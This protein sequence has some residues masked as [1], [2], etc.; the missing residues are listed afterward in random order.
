MTRTSSFSFATS[1]CAASAG[2]PA[3]I[4][5]V[6]AFSGK[7]TFR[8]RCVGSDAA[9]SAAS[10]AEHTSAAAQQ[11]THAASRTSAAAE[12]SAQAAKVTAKAAVVT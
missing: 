12:T 9:E 5:V 2:D 1:L 7:Y 8:M 6:L 4:W 11:T 10:A 3:I